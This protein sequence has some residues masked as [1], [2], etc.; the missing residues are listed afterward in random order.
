MPT[1]LLPFSKTKN[2]SEKK[3][4]KQK[5]LKNLKVFV[6]AAY[7]Q[8]E[9]ST[10]CSKIIRNNDKLVNEKLTDFQYFFSL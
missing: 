5:Y 8:I 2:S 3:K 7:C 6:C 4:K 10:L 1:H 9:V